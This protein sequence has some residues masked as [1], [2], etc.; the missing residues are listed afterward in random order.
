MKMD[1]VICGAAGQGV[2]TV[3]KILAR[4]ALAEGYTAHAVSYFGIAKTEGPV[5][6]HVRVG[7]PAGPS[8]K[9]KKGTAGLLLALDRLEAL[10]HVSYL[11]PGQLALVDET[12]VL[13]V[14]SFFGEKNYPSKAGVEEAFANMILRWVPATVIANKMGSAQLA[15]AVMLGAFAAMDPTLDR[16]HLVMAI[17]EELPSNADVEAEA[18]F[19]GFGYI[20]GRDL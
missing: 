6:S 19:A 5:V 3:S 15:G 9:I 8:P 11:A 18:F 12:G 14:S 13:P 16:D 17:R 20:T 10:R 7:T 4:A 2:I 1:M